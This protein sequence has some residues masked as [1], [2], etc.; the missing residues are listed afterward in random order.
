M[1]EPPLPPSFCWK[2]HFWSMHA[3]TLDVD[4]GGSPC[5]YDL[6]LNNDL[7]QSRFLSRGQGGGGAVLQICAASK[8]MVFQPFWSEMGY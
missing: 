5:L 3:F 8:G 2:L 7:I 1:F 4:R 6:L